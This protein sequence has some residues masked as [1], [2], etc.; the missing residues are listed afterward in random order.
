MYFFWKKL[1]SFTDF[2]YLCSRNACP[3]EGGYVKLTSMERDLRPL[4]RPVSKGRFLNVT[5]C[6]IKLRNF[7]SKY[8]GDATRGVY[9]GWFYISPAAIIPLYIYNKVYTLQRCTLFAY[10]CEGRSPWIH[11]SMVL[12]FRHSG[13]DHA[14]VC[15]YIIA[16][17]GRLY[18][19]YPYMGA[20]RRPDL[21]DKRGWIHT[22]TSFLFP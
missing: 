9:V 10:I 4:V 16:G 7:E 21:W 6:K 1:C 15:V 8:G 20:M 12:S 14:V 13:I 17:V 11:I 19:A 3:C 2:I 18:V 22:P 5:V